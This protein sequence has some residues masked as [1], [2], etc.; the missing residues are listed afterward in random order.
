MSC[1]AWDPPVTSS[2]KHIPRAW[3]RIHFPGLA[4]ERGSSTA[5][6]MGSW[7]C[8]SP[9][10]TWRIRSNRFDQSSTYKQ[11]N[12]LLRNT[13]SG[14]FQDISR[15]AGPGLRIVSSSRGAAFGDLD[16]DGDIDI[17][18]CNSREKPNVLINDSP[19]QNHWLGLTLRGKRD[20]FAMNAQATV[21]AKGKAQ[22]REVRSG[23]SYA[24]QNDL[25]LHFGLGSAKQVDKVE[26]RWPDGQTQTLTD[27]PI[28]RYTTVE[29]AD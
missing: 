3:P 19:P 20:R 27:L 25:R 22:C 2:M 26:I 24:S 21:Y 7:T 23:A 29:Q 6:T 18:V 4:G 10:V 14:K 1:I 9:M 28:D 13:G 17:V 15:Q 8:L 5:T 12:Q 11:P 16:N